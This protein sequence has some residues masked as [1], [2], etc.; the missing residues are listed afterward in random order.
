MR[1]WCH[2]IVSSYIVMSSQND[3]V[4]VCAREQPADMDTQSPEQDNRGVTACD[5]CRVRPILGARGVTV[6]C[7]TTQYHHTCHI[8]HHTISRPTSRLHQLCS[9]KYM[10][11]CHAKC[12]CN[13]QYEDT[14]AMYDLNMYVHYAM[15]PSHAIR[16][17]TSQT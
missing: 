15:R 12:V 9:V 17:H 4:C 2:D 3:S 13:M 1:N 8:H 7:N 11:L 16:P 10:R 5:A 14:Y 6:T